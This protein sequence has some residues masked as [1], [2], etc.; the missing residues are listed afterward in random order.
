M[1]IL[2]RLKPQETLGK[3]DLHEDFKQKI[4]GQT[5][6][7]GHENQRGP[8]P[9]F[10]HPDHKDGNE[11]R[12]KKKPQ[13]LHEEGHE[14]KACK[15]VKDPIPGNRI[16]PKFSSFL[17]LRA[18]GPLAEKQQQSDDSY[19]QSGQ[20]GNKSASWSARIPQFI[21]DRF[22]TNADAEEYPEYIKNMVDNL[23]IVHGEIVIAPS[24]GSEIVYQPQ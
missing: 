11:N 21:A 16:F 9:R 15:K 10:D 2:P 8:S 23:I 19:Q 17:L 14:A 3:I 7:N 13:F 4:D 24:H 6:E 1:S 5:G 20:K 12:G 18:L 22:D